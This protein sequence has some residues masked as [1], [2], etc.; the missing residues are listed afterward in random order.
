MRGWIGDKLGG[1]YHEVAQ[2]ICATGLF[3]RGDRV[4]YNSTTLSFCPVS[5]QLN[6]AACKSCGPEEEV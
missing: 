6:T 5:F 2:N 1:L 4:S 3:D